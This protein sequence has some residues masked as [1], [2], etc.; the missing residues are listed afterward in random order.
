MGE[1]KND[2]F[3]VRAMYKA[4]DSMPTPNFPLANIWSVCI[5]PK[6]CFFMWESTRGKILTLEQLQRRGLGL[7]NR[8]VSCAKKKR[9][10]LTIFSPLCFNTNALTF[11]FF[12]FLAFLG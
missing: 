12:L 7:A 11:T 2:D 5:Q 9:R 10:Q 6:L 3:S 8:C 4:M 1:T